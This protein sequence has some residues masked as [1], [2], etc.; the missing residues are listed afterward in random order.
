[1]AAPRQPSRRKP[2]APAPASPAAV[3]PPAPAPASGLGRRIDRIRQGRPP[4]LS[5]A[6]PIGGFLPDWYRREVQ[7]PMRALTQVAEAWVA[8]VP[9]SLQAR[10]MLLSFTRGVLTVAAPNAST[11]YDLDRFLAE[12]GMTALRHTLTTGAAFQRVRVRVEPARFLSPPPS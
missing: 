5:T 3:P 4:G 10:T 9:P 11:A 1:M 2:P 7:R 12:G 8:V 6:I